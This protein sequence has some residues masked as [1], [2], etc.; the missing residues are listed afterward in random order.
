MKS[1][2][3]TRVVDYDNTVGCLVTIVILVLLLGCAWQIEKYVRGIEDAVRDIKDT[4]RDIRDSNLR[5]QAIRE[6]TP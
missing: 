5:I 6:A 3:E 1:M 4:A 2:P